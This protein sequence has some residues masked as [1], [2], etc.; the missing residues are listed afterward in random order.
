M[1]VYLGRPSDAF[2]AP[3]GLCADHWAREFLKNNLKCAKLC[4]W[5][6]AHLRA[7]QQFYGKSKEGMYHL[8]LADLEIAG[9]EQCS[10]WANPSQLNCLLRG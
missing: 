9:L 6:A 5:I 4:A 8:L 3:S 1:L 2:P 10:E 7:Y